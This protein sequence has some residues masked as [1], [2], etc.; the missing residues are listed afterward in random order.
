MYILSR[1]LTEKQFNPDKIINGTVPYRMMVE[2]HSGTSRTVLLCNTSDSS[3]REVT[4]LMFEV[5]VYM[6]VL[7]R[8]FDLFVY[9]FLFT[10]PNNFLDRL[11]DGQFFFFFS[12]T[13]STTR[14]PT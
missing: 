2:H 4:P 13:E 1:Y 7:Q 11:W 12:D 10:K 9:V 8:L 5:P 3:V 6:V 14:L